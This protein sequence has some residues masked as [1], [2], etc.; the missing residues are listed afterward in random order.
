M[1]VHYGAKIKM[2]AM[3]SC[4]HITEYTREQFPISV[5]AATWEPLEDKLTQLFIGHVP[6]Q[7]CQDHW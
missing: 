3:H 5:T 4:M 2:Y 7:Q 6:S 1:F